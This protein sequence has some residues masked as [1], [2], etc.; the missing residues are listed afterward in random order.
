LISTTANK[1]N[2]DALPIGV[3]KT[4]VATAVKGWRVGDYVGLNCA[5]CHEG[6][7]EYKGKHVRIHGEISHTLDTTL[8]GN[9]NAGHPFQNGPRGDGVIGP[10]LKDEE[11]WALE[12][13]K[14]IPEETGR[15]T[16]LG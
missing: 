6:Q 7:L 11:R 10:L 13:L 16:A 8:L 4:V 15:V 14:S 2:P 1:Y 3:T 9:S 5:A 12:Y